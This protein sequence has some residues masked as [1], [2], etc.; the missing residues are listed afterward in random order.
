LRESR[1]STRN[2]IQQQIQQDREIFE[3]D[4]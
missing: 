2:N 1:S 3:M 4:L